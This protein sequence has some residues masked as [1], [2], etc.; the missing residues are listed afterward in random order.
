[1]F[2]RCNR[3]VELSHR[4][5]AENDENYIAEN[6]NTADWSDYDD[7]VKDP[8]YKLPKKKPDS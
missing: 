6:N 1:M 3:L 4:R 2:S 8:D 7:D 5:K